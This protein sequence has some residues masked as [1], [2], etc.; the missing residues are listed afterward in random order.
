MAPPRASSF[1]PPVQQPQHW[2]QPRP[3]QWQGGQQWQSGP[4]WQQP[5]QF[6][7]GPGQFPQ[8]P[9][10]FPQGPGPFQQWPP[11]GQF[12]PPRK[13][14]QPRWFIGAAAVLGVFLAFLLIRSLMAGSEPGPDPDTD[15][16]DGPAPIEYANEDY[17]VP[18]VSD[19]VPELVYPETYE[20]LDLY[21]LDNPIYEQTLPNPV[22]CDLDVEPDI[23]SF[24]DDELEERLAG[25]VECL[26]RVWGPTLEDAGFDAYQPRMTVYPAGG[27]VQ[28]QCGVQESLNAFFCGAD[29]NLYL[30]ADITRV[31]SSTTATSPIVYD[32]VIAHEYGHAMQ[33]RIGVFAS[34]KYVESEA[35][36]DVAMESSRRAEVQA[37]CFGGISLRVL[38]QSLGISEEDAAMIRAIA[39]DI[40]DDTLNDRFGGDSSA[41]GS[42][43]T[44]ANRLLWA[45]RGL[46]SDQLGTCNTWTAPSS[47]VR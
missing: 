2:Q 44:G 4:Q 17:N 24:T 43:G 38:S 18:A 28:T 21:L 20:D 6:R 1:G 27:T 42:H 15:P 22:R 32:V 47:E 45:G 35:E 26:T 11:P 7:P 9:G 14:R 12:T 30:A 29:Q 46:S 41:P 34:S 13:P 37:D 33:G 3:Q 19:D 40:G 10:H 23:H 36:E 8:A 39:E 16:T 25:L 31:L 5:H